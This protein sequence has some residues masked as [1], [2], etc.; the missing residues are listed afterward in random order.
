MSEFDQPSGIST[1]QLS[2]P[3][4]PVRTPYNYILGV[5]FIVCIEIWSELS[6][7]GLLTKITR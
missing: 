7:I 2:D 5:V 6:A 3:E 4:H 1:E